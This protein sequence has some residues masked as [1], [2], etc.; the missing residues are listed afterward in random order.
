MRPGGPRWFEGAPRFQLRALSA[1]ALPSF[2]FFFFGQ[3]SGGFYIGGAGRE[4]RGYG[5]KRAS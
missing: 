3:P 1:P 5:D 4:A 2:F